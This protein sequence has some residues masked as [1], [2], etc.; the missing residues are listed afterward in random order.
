M[1]KNTKTTRVYPETKERINCLSNK[2]TGV[3]L[4]KVSSAE[5]LRRMMSIPVIENI[6]LADAKEKRRNE[7]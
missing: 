5:L 6:L 1:K 4:K 2:L 3:Q 7:K